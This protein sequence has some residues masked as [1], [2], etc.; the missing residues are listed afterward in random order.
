MT[1]V[2]R[3]QNL[4]PNRSAEK[5]F[6]YEF[7]GHG[8]RARLATRTVAAVAIALAVNHATIRFHLDF[9]LFRVFGVR[10]LLSRLTAL[11]TVLLLD[12]QLD[13]FGFRR[14]MVVVATLRHDLLLLRLRGVR[15]VFVE[16]FERIRTIGGGLF[17]AGGA[18]LLIL[19]LAIVCAE[20]IVFKL[21]F[22]DAFECASVEA[23]VVSGLLSEFEVLATEVRDFGGGK[24]DVRAQFRE[25]WLRGIGRRFVC[26]KE[27]IHDRD[28]L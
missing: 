2:L 17:F 11:R 13:D 28:S 27:S 1:E 6:G 4:N 22:F 18:E 23:L 16:A 26:E 21:E 25:R 5:T 7:R 10:H 12:G 15:L 8:S 20:F 19:E 9:Q 14:Q 24:R 3:Q